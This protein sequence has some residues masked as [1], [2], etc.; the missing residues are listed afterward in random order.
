MLFSWERARAISR[1]ETFHIRRD[2]FTLALAL[3]VPVFVVTFFGLAIDFKLKEV[4]VSAVDMDRTQTSRIFLETLGSSNYFK[5]KREQH[6]QKLLQDIES[7]RAKLVLA[8]NGGF[9]KDLAQGQGQVQALL[10]GS[11]NSAVGVVQSY[12]LG[13]RGIATD[14]LLGIKL[15][16]PVKLRTRFLFNPELKTQWFIVPG[17][18]VVILG[19][20]SILLTSLTVAREWETGSM[21]LLL[22]TPVQPLEI[23]LGKLFPYL[24]LGLGAATFV[25]LV[26]RLVFHVPFLGS[27]FLFFL[28]CILF[29]GTYLI[30]GLL[31][32]IVLRKQQLSM[33]MAVMTGL[34]PTMLLSGFVFAIQD[35]PLFFRYF[36]GLLPARWFMVI[37]R[38]IFLKGASFNEL[39]LSFFVLMCANVLFMYL[40][41]ALF[42]KD[43]EQ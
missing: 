24:C 23:I 11:D 33:Q 43:L 2:P 20:L 15:E 6:L 13:I 7:E 22:S 16:L 31:I 3:G 17:L 1:K 40:S 26:A 38:G 5:V 41:A 21:E 29:L 42:R 25:Y 10:D 4:R 35:M 18:A 14:R 30:Q 39:S 37:C 9:A 27:H 12:I 28:G 19:T 32:S 36:T 8:I 34:L